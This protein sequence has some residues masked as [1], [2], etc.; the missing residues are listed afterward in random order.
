LAD[1]DAGNNQILNVSLQNL[2]VPPFNTTAEAASQGRSPGWL[3]FNTTAKKVYVYTGVSGSEW[4]DLGF[5]YSHPTVGAVN[6][7]LTGAKVLATLVTNAEGHITSVTTRDLTLGDLGYVPYSHPTF[8]GNDLG[9]ALT[10]AVVISDINV[11]TDGHV[12]G[13]ATRSLTPANIGASATGHTHTLSNI[14]DVTA[15]AA[16]VNL[17]DLAGLTA[18]WVLRATGPASAVWSK[19]NGSDITNDLNWCVI[20]DSATNTVNTWSSSKISTELAAINSTITGGLV[21]KGGYDAFA[22]SPMLDSTPIAGIKNG[23]TYVVTVAGNFFTEAVQIG[24]MIIAKQDSPTTLAHWTV[25]NK[26]IPDIVDATTTVKG[27][28]RFATDAEALAKTIDGVAGNGNAGQAA[29][30][31]KNLAAFISSE[32]LAGFISIATQA[33]VE[34][35]TDDTK[36]VTAKKLRAYNGRML[37]DNL[38]NGT[39][40]DIPLAHPWGTDVSVT[41]I[42]KA[43]NAQVECEV[44]TAVAGTATLKFNVAPTTAAL[45]AIVRR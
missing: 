7:T 6:P 24:D 18:G 17:L 29:I 20:N 41:V 44:V 38:G 42:D 2:A 3:Y 13:F 43:T 23:W 36:A 37:F 39:L 4:L 14:T 27:I 5:L 26:N 25:V 1:I 15:T 12:T 19:L 32:V 10:G 30:T 33:E 35:G 45:K 21:N 22:N 31:P 8:T 40:T 11:N 34:T 28:M 9:A 16:E